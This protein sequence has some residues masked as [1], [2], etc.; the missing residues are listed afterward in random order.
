MHSHSKSCKKYK[1]QKKYK[2]CHFN[3]G[4]FFTGETIIAQP[5]KH[6][7]NFERFSILEKRDIILS[8]ISEYING[9]L[10]PS[11]KSYQ[12]STIKHVLSKL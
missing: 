3:F 2:S 12:P 7:S 1:I 9:Y 5:I 8:K 11:K 10:D 4:K 6:V